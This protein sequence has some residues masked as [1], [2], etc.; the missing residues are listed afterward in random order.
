MKILTFVKDKALLILGGIVVA[1]VATI[2]VM[3]II[4]SRNKEKQLR[5]AAERREYELSQRDRAWKALKE[6]LQNEKSSTDR[7]YFDM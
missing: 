3:G 2:R 1:L 5:E 7:G 6:G 4:M